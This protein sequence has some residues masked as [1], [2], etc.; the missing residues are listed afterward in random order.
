MLLGTMRIRF[1]NTARMNPREMEW[2][3]GNSGT[4]SRC[5]A[6]ISVVENLTD[7]IFEILGKHIS[8]ARKQLIE[9]RVGQGK[10]RRD[11]EINWKGVCAV[12]GIATGA[13]L[14]AS[15][16]KPWSISNNKEKLDAANGLLLC[17]NI[18]A[19]FD[20]CLISFSDEGAMLV[21]DQTEENEGKN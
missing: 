16:I 7:D 9:A 8:T 20:R 1:T 12:T 5:K 6:E 17:A 10:S 14:R 11:L 18:D 4:F 15:H 21:S 19:M 2:K 13:A 3:S